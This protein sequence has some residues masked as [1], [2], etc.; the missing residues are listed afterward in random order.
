MKRCRYYLHG[1][2]NQFLT[3]LYNALQE[4][5]PNLGMIHDILKEYN[6]IQQYKGQMYIYQGE[7]SSIALNHVRRINRRY[8]NLIDYEYKGQTRNR[9]G[10]ERNEKYTFKINTAVLNNIKNMTFPED[11]AEIQAEEELLARQKEE[12]EMKLAEQ[13]LSEQVRRENTSE[14]RALYGKEEALSE[15][16][17]KASKL[18]DV[19]KNVGIKTRIEFTNDLAENVSADVRGVGPRSAVIRLNN[20]YLQ[21]DSVYHEFGHIYVDLLG[22]QNPLIRQALKQLQG[23]S[24]ALDVID[25]YPHLDGVKLDKEILATAIGI[26]GAKIERKNPSKF[27]ILLNKIFRSIGKMFG[28]RQNAAAVLAEQ[29]FAGELRSE[30]FVGN[31]SGFTQES[32]DKNSLQKKIDEVRIYTRQ[33][34][35]IAEQRNDAASQARAESLEETLESVKTLEDFISFIDMSA[36]ITANIANK[37]QLLENKIKNGEKLDSKDASSV[38]ELNEYIRGFDILEGLETLFTTEKQGMAKHTTAFQ[39]TYDKLGAVV[40]QRR[41]LQDQYFRIVIPA[42]ADFLTPYISQEVNENIDSLIQNIDEQE[43][44]ENK[45][46]AAT[47]HLDKKSNKFVSLQNDLRTNRITKEEYDENLIELVKEQLESKKMHKQALTEIL[48]RASK[49]ASKFSFWLDPLVYSND[50]AIQLFALAVK[51][52]LIKGED[53]SRDTAYEIMNL[54]KEFSEGKSI[55]NV[56]KLY[57]EMLESVKTWV[58]D[59]KGTYKQIDRASIVQPDD[60]NR[61]QI[62][63]QKAVIEAKNKTYFRERKDFESDEL[64]ED[65]LNSIDNYKVNGKIVYRAQTRD[66]LYRLTRRAFGEAMG[67]WRRENTVPKKDAQQIMEKHEKKIQDLY[68]VMRPFQKK[69]DDNTITALEVDQ[70]TTYEMELSILDNWR[71]TNYYVNPRYPSQLTPKGSLLRPSRGEKMSDGRKRTD[72]TNPKYKAIMANPKSKKFYEGVLKIYKEH[73]DKLG[74]AGHQLGRDSFSEMSYMLPSIRKVDKD[75]LIEKGVLPTL[76]EWW[77]DGTDITETDQHIYGQQWETIGGKQRKVVPAFYTNAVDKKDISLDITSSLLQFV[78][79][80]NTYEAKA[81]IQAEIQIMTDIIESRETDLT[82]P[83]G[84]K[85]INSLAKGLG[86]EQPRSKEGHETNNFKHLTS[87]LDQNIYGEKT[88]KKQ[89]TFL[90]KQFEAN[91]LSGKLAGY[92]AMNALSFNL[93]QGVNQ[94]VLDN[95]IGWSEAAAGQFV[96]R[97]SVLKAKTTYWSKGGGIGDLGKIAPTTFVG[98]MLNEYDMIQGQFAKTN[99]KNVTGSNAKKLFSSDALFF[100]QHGAE[101]E[102]QVTRGMAMLEFMKAKDK[103]GKQLKNPDGSDM[104]M[105]DAHSQVNGRLKIDPRVA[106]FDKVRFMNRLHGINKRTNGV[107]NQFDS[108]HLKRHWYGKLVM[109]FRGWMVPGYRRRFGHG[110]TWHS[111][112]EL[113]ALTQGTYVTFYKMLRDSIKSQSNQYKNMS[114]LEKQNIRRVAIEINSLA[115]SF[116]LS[117]AAALLIDPDDEEP[118]SWATNFLLYQNRRLRSELLFYVN[119]EETWRLTKSPT[120]TVRPIEN[121]F[122]FALSTL[123]N[124]YYFGTGNMGG[125][126]PEKNIYYQR[127]SGKNKKGELKWDNKLEK[128]VPILKGVGTSTTPGEAI[129][130]FNL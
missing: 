52:S 127:K 106:N 89:F 120:A 83:S 48:T 98:Q 1:R 21:D 81:S 29:M 87:F 130:W 35:K 5:N 41:S 68:K 104:T 107:Y 38:S 26:E 93:L 114:E 12:R 66:E 46:V 50:N 51:D 102:V 91:K 36:K 49:D 10:H 103:N 64:F 37:Y 25:A 69:V 33:L 65:Y 129:K 27:R 119:P 22:M 57:G 118:N 45:V 11:I 2:P 121:I 108:N 80:A 31:I 90:G 63:K 6:V 113:G 58:R 124:M 28:I 86:I 82:S 76:K 18:Q 126:I 42:M 15:S 19:F 61:Y 95:I 101:H 75:M 8:P 100:L 84:I 115:G 92:T 14:N 110:E 13:S 40:R 3:H 53:K 72:Y 24:I 79:M 116:L 34:K 17:K 105:L 32:R 109:L 30:A 123:E 128:A 125:L 7:D 99:G 73:Q 77:I 44:L 43:T 54:Y 60:M 9:F 39:T 78:A 59:E 70:L 4:R 111:D 122:A 20:E 96:D 56:E 112:H 94:N 71:Q 74:S 47:R 55:N 23:S 62:N 88:I 67:K 97:K 16:A 117:F 85:I